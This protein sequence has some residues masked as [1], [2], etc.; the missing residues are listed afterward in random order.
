MLGD[1]VTALGFGIA[2][3]YGI[4]GFACA[5]YYRRE[6]TRNDCKTFVYAGVLPVLGGLLLFGLFIKAFIDYSNPDNTNTS[7]LGVGRRW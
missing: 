1:S 5:W 6:L 7:F 3:Y 2:F 4:T